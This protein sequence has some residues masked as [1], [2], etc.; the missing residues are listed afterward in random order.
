MSIGRNRGKCAERFIATQVGGKRDLR[1]GL[2]I[3]D[4]RTEYAVY[5]V[6]ERSKL[7]EWMNYAMSQAVGDPE[8]GTKIPCVALV[9]NQHKNIYIMVRLKDWQDIT[10]E[11]GIK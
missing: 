9:E 4:V 2:Q 10:G 7:P 5:E 1:K 6:K 8:L 11:K 3:S